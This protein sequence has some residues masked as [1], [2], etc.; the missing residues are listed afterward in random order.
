MASKTG[1]ILLQ[2]FPHSLVARYEDI[3]TTLQTWSSCLLHY[4]NYTFIILSE[5]SLGLYHF[6]EDYTLLKQTL[7][8]VFL[9]VMLNLNGP[10]SSST[11]CN[12]RFT[13]MND[14]QPLSSVLSLLFIVNLF[15]NIMCIRGKFSLMKYSTQFDV[16]SSTIEFQIFAICH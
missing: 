9:P 14:Q 1:T 6:L 2:T 8:T 11:S 12:F 15:E 5:Y 3:F 7:S 10:S 4:L 13:C 16:R